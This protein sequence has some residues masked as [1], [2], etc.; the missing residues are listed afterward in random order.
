MNDINT[1]IDEAIKIE[2]ELFFNYVKDN[3]EDFKRHKT[4]LEKLKKLKD[5]NFG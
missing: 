2:E 4:R 3:E 1:I 5:N